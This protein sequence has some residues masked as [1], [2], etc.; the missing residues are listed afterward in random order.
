M[1]MKKRSVRI[2]VLALCA[3]LLCA[4]LCV[5]CSAGVETEPGETVACAALSGKKS[6]TYLLSGALTLD[7]SA[8][9]AAQNEFNRFD[10][11]YELSA[12]VRGVVSYTTKDGAYT[13]EFYLSETQTSFSQLIDSYL[14]KKNALSLQS[15]TVEPLT[16]EPCSFRLKSAALAVQPVEDSVITIENDRY[17]LGVKISMGGALSQLEDKKSPRED[18]S[19]LLNHHDTGRLIQQSY[20]G[21]ASHPDYENGRYMGNVWP[22]NPVQGGDVH[23]NKSKI[24]AISK[25]E[26]SITVVSR[27]LDWGKKDSLTYAYYSNT[28]TLQEDLVRVDNTVI[29]F[30][31]FPN[32]VTNQELPAFYTLSALGNFVYYSGSEP[33]TGDALTYRTDLGFWGTDPACSHGLS[34]ENTETWCAWVDENDYGVGLFTPNVEWLK[35]GRYHYN[36]STNSKADA[37][38]YVAPVCNLA[39]TPYQPISY[40]YLIGAGTVEELRAAFAAN[41]DFTDNADLRQTMD[42]HYDFSAI[43]FEAEEDLAFVA[44]PYQTAVAYENGCAVLTYTGGSV[45]DPRVSLHY[46]QNSEELFAQDYP[47]MVLTYRTGADNSDAAAALELF[48]ATDTLREAK[49]GYSTYGALETDGAFHSMILPLGELEFWNGRINLIRMDYFTGCEEGDTLYLYS[50]CLAESEAAAQKIADTQ[51]KAA[52]KT[53]K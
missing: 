1:R 14:N 27:P 4:L 13:E 51:L 12:P 18:I 49:G 19:N 47:Y 24:V 41:K 35:A 2:G 42:E 44:D 7:F 26:D 9:A 30:S 29:D 43:H 10:L 20:Y 34:P 53:L 52:E 16:E 23:N 50:A 25:T 15:I 37:T 31:G 5:G 3:A 33:W 36:G 39:L 6:E 48:L 21:V 38:N 46:S 32:P 45:A 17:I 28:Y 11:T 22:Y 40:S 8:D